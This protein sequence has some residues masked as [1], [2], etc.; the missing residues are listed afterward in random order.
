MVLVGTVNLLSYDRFRWRILLL[1]LPKITVVFFSLIPITIAG[2][3]ILSTL[4]GA[5]TGRFVGVACPHRCG[6]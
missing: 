4:R 1:R 2:Y 3:E 5:E 6:Y